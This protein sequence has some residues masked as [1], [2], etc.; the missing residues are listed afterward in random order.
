MTDLPNCSGVESLKQVGR[1]VKSLSLSKLSQLSIQL[2]EE[3][4]FIGSLYSEGRHC[5]ARDV[6]K[7]MLHREAAGPPLM[8]Q[9]DGVFQLWLGIT[10]IPHASPCA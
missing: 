7:K 2:E 8:M 10:P 3:A 4:P 9:L 1:R 5:P 6:P